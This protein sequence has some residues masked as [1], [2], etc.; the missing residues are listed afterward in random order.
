MIKLLKALGDNIG[1]CHYLRV[2]KDF[3]SK[4]YKVLGEK[5]DKLD[6]ITIKNLA[7][8]KDAMKSEK[9]NSE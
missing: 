4:K 3:V 2:R 9:V 1:E 6:Y 5:T 7:L 8:S